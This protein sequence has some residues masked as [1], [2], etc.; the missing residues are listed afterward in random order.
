MTKMQLAEALAEALNI[1]NGLQAELD[2]SQQN[3][4]HKL[5]ATIPADIL[6]A[7]DFT[8]NGAIRAK[9]LV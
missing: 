3:P 6:E 7:C 4:I 1:L 8:N 9:S 2:S 5:F